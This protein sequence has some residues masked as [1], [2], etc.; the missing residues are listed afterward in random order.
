MVPED[1]FDGTVSAP[2][3]TWNLHTT[4]PIYFDP[5]YN[6]VVNLTGLLITKD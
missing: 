2:A 6:E 1:V 3:A 4:Q 5:T